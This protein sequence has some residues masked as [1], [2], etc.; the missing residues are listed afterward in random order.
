MK[1]IE[2][3]FNIN[4][5]IQSLDNGGRFYNIQTKAKD[6]IINQSE[7][8]KVGGIFNDKQQMILFLEMSILKLNQSDKNS[9]ISTL[10]S[11]LKKTFQKYKSLELLPSEANS[12]GIISSNAIITGIP[13]LI[14][15]K[16][17]IEGFILF[18][19]MSGNVTTIMMIPLI[20]E[21]D[22]YELRDEESSETFLIAHLKDSER[23][24]SKKMIIGGVL[25]ELNK[26]EAEDEAKGKFLEAVY[27]FEY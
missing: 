25:K 17:N 7:L 10:D 12:K 13:K 23:L 8:G 6:G 21:F 24:P 14:D 22:V 5:A 27:H 16:S 26:S 20:D 15:S 2:P 9:I 3:Y 19:I 18:P 4:E 1:K 11:D